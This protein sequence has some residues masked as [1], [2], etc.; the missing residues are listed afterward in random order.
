M[1]KWKPISEYNEAEC[2]Y[3]IVRWRLNS[4]KFSHYI[5]AKIK[6]SYWLTSCGQPIAEPDEFCEIID[7]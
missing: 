6:N 5:A 7:E 4:D 3:V 2:E 1:F